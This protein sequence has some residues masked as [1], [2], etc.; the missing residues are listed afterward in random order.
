MLSQPKKFEFIGRL[1]P[2]ISLPPT[3]AKATAGNAEAQRR[4]VSA[5]NFRAFC[6]HSFATFALKSRGTPHW[7]ARPAINPPTFDIPF[8]A[9]PKS[10]LGDL[11]TLGIRLCPPCSRATSSSHVISNKSRSVRTNSISVLK[12]RGTPQLPAPARTDL[13]SLLTVHCSLLF[14]HFT[15]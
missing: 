3:F 7:H 2:R 13:R 8:A 6:G 5:G 12:N 15:L 11:N 14:T 9:T 10:P 1:A 4:K